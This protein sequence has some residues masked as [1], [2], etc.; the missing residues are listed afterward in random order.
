MDPALVSSGRWS[1]DQCQEFLRGLHAVE[2]V[3]GY[4]VSRELSD[5]AEH[6]QVRDLEGW[7]N[8]QKEMK[9][10]FVVDGGEINAAALSSVRTPQAIDDE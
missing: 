10:G 7:R 2:L 6:G 5:L 1:I 4:R 9:D 3:D 8:D